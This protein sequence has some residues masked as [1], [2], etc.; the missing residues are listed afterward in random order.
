MRALTVAP[1]R[2]GSLSL[3]EVEEPDTEQGR[4]LAEGLAVGV[5][6]RIGRSLRATTAGLLRARS[7]WSSGTSP[8]AGSARRRRRRASQ[9]VT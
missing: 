3:D 2:I 6:G 1:G 8:S 7:A 5:E 4:I 9:G